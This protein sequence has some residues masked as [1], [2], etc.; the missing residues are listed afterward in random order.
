[1]KRFFTFF[2]SLVI[3][4]LAGIFLKTGNCGMFKQK[5]PFKP[6][7]TVYYSNGVN[8]FRFTFESLPK[9]EI[10]AEGK[11]NPSFSK[12]RQKIIF[13]HADVWIC[14]KNGKNKRRLKEA[15]NGEPVLSPDEDKIAYTTHN[16]ELG[17]IYL[18]NGERDEIIAE[19]CLPYDII[20]W[21]SNDE[22]IY[23]KGIWPLDTKIK[24]WYECMPG[25]RTQI[26]INTKQKREFRYK[27][28]YPGTL[29]PDGQYLLCSKKS[30]FYELGAIY[31]L[32]VQDMKL[33]KLTRCGGFPHTFI[34][35]P[36]GRYFLFCKYRHP[37][38]SLL[39]G[40]FE[41]MDIYVYSL[42]HK[43]MYRLIENT[44]LFGGFWLEEEE[45]LVGV[46]PRKQN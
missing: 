5:I 31:L 15:G 11:L 8:L 25:T 35:S 30:S 10:I 19:D 36:D 41:L 9:T 46:R 43:K 37:L 17:I 38:I 26:N 27:K 40:A 23:T 13:G 7:G 28:I 45:D 18:N 6:P 42:E 22:L 21:I 16:G 24:R 1:M 14:D 12:K 34:W 4:G 33:T 20:V 29:S 44:A 39:H 32:Q 2:I 3:I